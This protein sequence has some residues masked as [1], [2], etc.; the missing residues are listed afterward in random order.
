MLSE[1]LLA[2]EHRGGSIVPRFLAAGDEVWVRSLLDAARAQEGMRE[3]D[4]RAAMDA[5]VREISKAQRVSDAAVSGMR[6]VLERSFP[7]RTKACVPPREARRALFEAAARAGPFRIDEAA[8]AAA[9]RMGCSPEEVIGSAYADFPG[10]RIITTAPSAPTPF[11]LVQTYNLAL[12][13]GLLLRSTRVTVRVREHVRAV[14]RFAKLKRLLCSCAAAGD[15]MCVELSGPL[16]LFHHTTRYGFSLASFL[17]AVTATPG[18][19]MEADLVLRAGS[20][21]L[22]VDSGAPLA[23]AHALPREADSDVERAL[24][25][26]VRKLGGKWQLA[27]ETRAYET[28]DGMAFPDFTLTN[29]TSSVLVEVVGFWTAEYLARKLR[30]LRSMRGLP[31][32]L[33]VDASLGVDASVAAEVVGD[34]GGVLRFRGR[35]DAG[36]LVRLA[37]EMIGP[38]PGRVVTAEPALAASRAICESG[39]A[40]PDHPI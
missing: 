23:R 36:A 37:E 31:I 9:R 5:A 22:Y 26:D 18:W 16:A 11:E 35:I 21:R 34:I 17:P 28:S 14:L 6:V 39:D 8:A 7:A 20:G 1:K 4:A 19:S 40:A 29:G 15:H 24:S 32:I 3:D 30:Q 10:E 13:Q 38:A 25:R 33:C 27:R 12:V 2:V